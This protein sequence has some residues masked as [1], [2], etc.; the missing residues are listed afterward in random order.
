MDK[1]VLKSIETIKK[2][3]LLAD[4]TYYAEVLNNF[5]VRSDDNEK[6]VKEFIKEYR[7]IHTSQLSH[8]EFEECEQILFEKLK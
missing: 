4:K 5:L 7:K 8:D 6:A 1:R 3:L 2:E